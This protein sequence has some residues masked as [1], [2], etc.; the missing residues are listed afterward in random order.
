[1][2]NDLIVIWNRKPITKD[3]SPGG[4]AGQSCKKTI[5]GSIYLKNYTTDF[6]HIF[7]CRSRKDDQPKFTPQA[8]KAHPGGRKEKSF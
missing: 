2:K 8:T 1:M 3:F 6:C 4:R 7:L 5:F